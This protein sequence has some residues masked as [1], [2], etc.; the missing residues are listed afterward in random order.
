MPNKSV[1]Q[2]QIL[3]VLHHFLEV[4]KFLHHALQIGEAL[5]GSPKVFPFVFIPSPLIWKS[6]KCSILLLFLLAL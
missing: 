6:A 5:I 1:V 4:K 2:C 3:K